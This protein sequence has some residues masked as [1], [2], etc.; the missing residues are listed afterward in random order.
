MRIKQ[1]VKKAAGAG[2][3]GALLASNAACG[4]SG[5][6][7]NLMTGIQAVSTDQAPAFDGTEI[8]KIA[9]VSFQLLGMTEA[10]TENMMISPV[11]ILA[12]LSM[13]ANGAKGDTL[14]QMQQISAED[15]GLHNWLQ[16]LEKKSENRFTLANS[17]W[18]RNDNDRFTISQEFLEKNAK[19]L[20]AEIFSSD[21]GQDTVDAINGWV[22]E[23]T[24]GMIT[25]LID[26]ID[27]QTIMHLI[28]AV[29]FEDKWKEPYEK[30]DVIA[31]LFT[32]IKGKKQEAEYLCSEEGRYIK[33]G[34]TVGV[35]KPYKHGFSFVA[36][37]P[38]EGVSLEEYTKGLDGK[39]FL[40]LIQ[41][42]QET[43]VDTKILKFKSEYSLEVK[44]LLKKMG[45]TDAFDEEKADFSGMGNFKKGSLYISRVFH[46]TFIEVEEEGTR[47]SAVTDIT[48]K[49]TAAVMQQEKVKVELTRPFL[50]AIIDDTTSLPVFVGTVTTM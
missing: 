25:K 2:L 17:I 24:R 15:H 8:E 38:A 42:A 43:D 14:K 41:N 32:N 1:Y 13:T 5:S 44:E 28:N 23:N 45:M 35:I 34:K 50:Y 27:A 22:K 10:G 30:E 26:Q 39:K 47:A 7:K 40:E 4:T 11:S 21:F 31:D 3:I 9:K 49:E 46:K 37:L 33:D 19:T 48:M 12:A 16:E 18:I 29:A 36:L 20:H 6:T